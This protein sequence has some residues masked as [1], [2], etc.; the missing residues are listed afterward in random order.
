MPYLEAMRLR[1]GLGTTA[2]LFVAAV[3]AS[4]AEAI[5]TGK[6]TAVAHESAAIPTAAYEAFSLV[7]L[8]SL[9]AAL[10]LGA[11]FDS[12]PV[13]RAVVGFRRG[14][15]EAR[16][17]EGLALAVLA[18]SVAAATFVGRR[19]SGTASVT[20]NVTLSFV[21]VV[22][23]G[24]LVVGAP[25]VIIVA[26]AIGPRL[27]GLHRRLPRWTLGYRG[28]V[29]AALATSLLVVA[30]RPL[31]PE[32]F[33]PTL[34]GAIVG[35]ALSSAGVLRISVAR[36]LGGAGG[37]R[38]LLVLG[39]LLLVALPA[40]FVL[41]RIPVAARL[42]VLYRSPLSGT[43]LTAVRAMV[44]RDHDG[45]SP[46]LL[47]GDCNDHDPQIN[48]AASD[49]P[50]N[51]IDE[52]C[53]GSDA[54]PYVPYRQPA[55]ALRG[56][57]PRPAKPN[58]VLIMIDALRPDH[59]HFAGYPRTTSPNL[60]AFRH[61]ATWFENA[62]TA[63]A[64]T[65]F[66]LASVM[67][68]FDV[69]RI[70]QT[71]SRVDL[72]V[73][74]SARLLGQ[75]FAELG[76]DRVGYTISYVLQ[77]I[78][79]VGAGFRVWETP[80]PVDDW[81]ENFAGAAARTT[82]SALE[83]LAQAPT[84]GTKPFVLFV[85]YQCTHNPYAQDPRWHFGDGGPNS[86]DAYDSALASCDDEVGRLL[87]GLDARADK[88]QTATLVF[89]DHGELFGEHGYT[90]HGSSVFQP[91]VRVLLLARMPFLYSASRLPQSTITTPVSLVDLEP[92]LVTLAGGTDAET[93]AWNLLPLLVN[94]DSAGD[95][96]RPL[97]LYTD[98]TRGAVRHQARGILQGRLKYVRDLTTATT[99]LYDIGADP[100]ESKDLSRSLPAERARLA[101]RLES[102][103]RGAA[104][105]K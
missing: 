54:T 21:V 33:L 76:Y 11:L 13:R 89:S 88:N 37:R 19:S 9:A 58:V 83:Y 50:G 70:P 7:L 55:A 99:G 86:I 6:A 3:C 82:N 84:D 103:E 96:A 97:I 12:R 105:A 28:L 51:G 87:R 79:G 69:E 32:T 68:G 59:L 60:D 42:V 52:N 56:L 100:G 77:H 24:S 92:T 66:S 94:G 29:P 67:T 45:Y 16:G 71:R 62:Y 85:H 43:I 72:E 104:T 74:P 98:L 78:R 57:P 47:G 73:L 44:D 64:S 49:L 101:D 38:G 15:P 8:P 2:R 30:A 93:H 81:R 23:L 75:R 65:R 35:Y 14:I 26:S 80:W 63:A 1:P 46:I 95:P 17:I 34:S 22:L 10:L 48:P 18:L 36:A 41:G 102:W 91:D 25:L 39:A 61:G 90:E 4:I 53:S 31:F 40:P 27:R 20:A 5:E